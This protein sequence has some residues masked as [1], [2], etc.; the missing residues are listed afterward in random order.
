MNIIINIGNDVTYKHATFYYKIL[1]IVDY[2][3]IKIKPDKIY[4]FENIHT[5]ISTFF[6]FFM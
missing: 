5:Q 1:C 4:R 3:K 6:I 2:T